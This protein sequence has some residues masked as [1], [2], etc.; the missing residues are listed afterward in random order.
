MLYGIFKRGVASLPARLAYR[1]GAVAGYTALPAAV[2]AARRA[3]RVGGY[4]AVVTDVPL[5]TGAALPG[6]K[7]AYYA[8]TVTRAGKRP[9]RYA[10]CLVASYGYAVNYAYGNWL[11]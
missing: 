11:A 2:R 3:A 6:G 9:G 5:A 1:P 4:G 7:R 10:G 8:V